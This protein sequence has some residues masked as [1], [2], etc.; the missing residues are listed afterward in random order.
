MSLLFKFSHLYIKLSPIQTN[1]FKLPKSIFPLPSNDVHI[2][3]KLSLIL[4]MLGDKIRFE[5]KL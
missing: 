1:F 3:M 2:D 5:L 4:F